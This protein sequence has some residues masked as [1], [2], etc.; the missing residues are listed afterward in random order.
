MWLKFIVED[1]LSDGWRLTLAVDDRPESFDLIRK[2]LGS[3]LE[4]VTILSVWEKSGRRL[5]GNG[6]QAV[7]KCLSQAGGRH[8][9]LDTFD[10]IASSLLRNAAI[11]RKPP[12]SLRGRIGGIYLRPR[13]LADQGFSLNNWIKA[14]GLAR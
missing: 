11:G 14:V 8:G 6:A 12:D 7:A 13:F 1:L 5:G 2:R 9:F 10:E 3:L 4:K